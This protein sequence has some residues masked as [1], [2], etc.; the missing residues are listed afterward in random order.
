MPQ[1]WLEA[2]VGNV[3]GPGPAKDELG[4][5]HIITPEEWIALA[6]AS[7]FEGGDRVAQMIRDAQ[8][9]SSL[10]D[11]QFNRQLEY[12]KAL[13]GLDETQA[14][15]GLYGAQQDSVQTESDQR[16]QLLPLEVQ[17][18]QLQLK[19][20]QFKLDTLKGQQTDLADAQ[21]A[22]TQAMT[23]LPAWNDPQYESK[24]NDWLDKNAHLMSRQDSVGKQLQTAYGLVN[25][26]VQATSDFQ[27]KLGQAKELNLL[28]Q[29]GYLQSPIN[30][31]QL[32]FSGQAEPTLVRGR[33][34]KNLD[35][36]QGLIAD[37]RLP[38]AQKDQ[39]S[40]LYNYG[41]GF[42]GSD[43]GAYDVMNNKAHDLFS[44]TGNFNGTAQ[45]LI[46]GV[47][48]M[49]PKETPKPAEYEA[50]IPIPNLPDIKL[51]EKPTMKVKGTQ[52]QIQG[53]LTPFEQEEQQKTTLKAIT[54]AGIPDSPENTADRAAYQR[55]EITQDQLF[56][57]VRQRAMQTAPARPSPTPGPSPTPTQAPP[58]GQPPPRIPVRPGISEAEPQ[59]GV[60]PASYAQ[61]QPER[62]PTSNNDYRYPAGASDVLGINRNVWANVMSEEGPDFGLDPG[63]RHMSVFG[64]WEGTPDDEREAYRVA[65]EYGPNSPDAYHAVTAAWTNKFLRQSRPWELNSPGLQEMV[66]ADSQH[67]GG[68][69]AR[70][71][72]DRMGGYDAVNSMRP[73]QA[74]RMY[75]EMRAPL[76]PK[77]YGRVERERDW[78]LRYN[79]QLAGSA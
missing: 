68:A 14:K 43:T 50:T 18:K 55:G 11:Q 13:A 30:A 47:N 74:I 65:R 79:D 70:A 17:A 63:T 71:I 42:L 16:K 2:P 59:A 64:L 4:Q 49:L 56:Q 66:I 21:D 15:I 46:N 25:G 33:M 12:R 19:D 24:I 7:G 54:Q 57:R 76:W 51:G 1:G 40:N 8:L 45:G 20:N 67:R 32:A 69:S 5:P 73:D 3:Q 22:A 6:K 29:G 41:K 60:Q 34:A 39:L 31:D 78:A 61:A 52:E 37:P 58:P 77:N 48:A 27:N 53:A 26:R 35:Q 75:S 9:G 28:Q 23:S 38:Q 62:T 36:L 10:V 72:I 44:A